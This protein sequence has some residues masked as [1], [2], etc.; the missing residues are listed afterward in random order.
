MCPDVL[1]LT[2]LRKKDCEKK[3]P[4]SWTPFFSYKCTIGAISP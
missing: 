1:D 4:L 3:A 2:V